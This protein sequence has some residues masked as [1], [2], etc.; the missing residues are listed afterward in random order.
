VA[1]IHDEF[2]IELPET[3]DHT[4]EAE[5]I[6]ELVCGAMSSVVNSTVPVRAEYVLTRCWSKRAK[7]LRD[8]SGRLQPWALEENGSGAPMNMANTDPG[9]CQ[10]PRAEQEGEKYAA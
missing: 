1:F 7:L 6:E 9:P 8:T 2:V 4:K 3:A 10:E 5:R